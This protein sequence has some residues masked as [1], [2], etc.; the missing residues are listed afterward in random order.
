LLGGAVGLITGAVVG[1]SMD[2]KARA[3][4]YEQQQI[5]RL[6]QAVS[7][8]D[9]MAMAQNGLGDDVIINH[10]REN[11]VQRKIEVSDVIM[12]HRNGVSEGVITAMQ[13]ARVGGPAVVAPPAVQYAP[14]PRVVVQEYYY[15]PP[16][17]YWYRPHWGYHYHHYHHHHR[18]PSSHFHWGV[19]FGR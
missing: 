11:G 2:E 9:V 15:A 16:P 8:Q 7:T 14:P 12:L 3:H 19:T 6:R 13:N 10:I 5:Y 1:N 18:P 17:P 4:A